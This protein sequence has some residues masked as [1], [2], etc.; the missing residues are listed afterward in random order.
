MDEWVSV[1]IPHYFG[2]ILRRFSFAHIA[3]GI[4]QARFASSICTN[5][6][7]LARHIHTHG[8]ADPVASI[9]CS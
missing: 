2:M 7:H 9:V 6:L 5:T 8:V 4:W 1:W 3:F